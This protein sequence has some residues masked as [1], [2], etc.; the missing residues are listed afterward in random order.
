MELSNTSTKQPIDLVTLQMDNGLAEG[1]GLYVAGWG[2]TTSNI[3]SQLSDKLKDVEV[4]LRNHDECAANYKQID[5]LEI[6]DNMLC[7]GD[8][9]STRDSCNGDSGG[10]LMLP[11]SDNSFDLVGI[12]SFGSTAGCAQGEYPGV[13]TRVSRYLDWI[14]DKTGELVT[15]EI[16]V[17]PSPLDFGVIDVGVESTKEVTLTNSGTSSMVVQS[18]MITGDAQFTVQSDSCEQQVLE[19]NQ[20][21]SVVIH[22]VSETEGSKAATLS[23]STTSS[24]NP[25]VT[26]E[27]SA[28][29]QQKADPTPTVV[30]TAIPTVVPTSIPTVVPTSIPTLD[31]NWPN[32]PWPAFVWPIF[33][34]SVFDWPIFNWLDY[35][36][37]DSKRPDEKRHEEKRPDTRRHDA[38]QPDLDW[39]FVRP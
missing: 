17:S 11:G 25:T 16:T 21:C 9:A 26:V 13:Y 12:V 5:Q 35:R 3:F 8:T 33:D 20:Q 29:V 2:K 22:F 37:S 1:V 36:G 14:V 38:K 30:P 10:P 28:E 6:T 15:D 18:T 4:P 24:Q 32:D 19:A 7:A 27:T 39:S 34:W 31:P 23:F